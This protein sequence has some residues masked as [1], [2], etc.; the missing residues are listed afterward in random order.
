MRLGELHT[1]RLDV[2][3]RQ[4]QPGHGPLVLWAEKLSECRGHGLCP[5]Y[6]GAH[7]IEVN[8]LLQALTLAGNLQDLTNSVG[9]LD[10]CFKR[11]DH[12][13]CFW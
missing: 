1:G 9:D 11:L 2:E 6:L 5:G 10:F 12:G 3:S 7:F 13:V 8:D 4:P